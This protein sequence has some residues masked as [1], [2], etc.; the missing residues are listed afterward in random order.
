MDFCQRLHVRKV[1]E[2]IDFLLDYHDNNKRNRGKINKK[3]K[4]GMGNFIVLCCSQ[5]SDYHNS[6]I[7]Q[8][9]PTN[10][11]NNPMS[12]SQRT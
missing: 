11:E 8:K 7:N 3:E 1:V 10:C 5:E 4:R 2:N 12:Q 6:H 9:S